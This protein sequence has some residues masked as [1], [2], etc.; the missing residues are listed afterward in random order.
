MIQLS[1]DEAEIAPGRAYRWQLSFPGP[2]PVPASRRPT[3]FNQAAHLAAARSAQAVNRPAP[4]ALAIACGF[5]LPGSV[6]LPTLEAAFL[7]LVCRHEVLR[8]H[9][10]HTDRGVA[11]HVRAPDEARL[12]R[13]EAGRLPS[14]TA[15][16]AHLHELLRLVDP[17]AGPLV[18]MG[19]VVRESSTTV[20]I[21]YDH[22]VA[23]LLSAPITVADLARAYDDLAH[24][25]EPDPTPAGSY[26]DFAREE[27]AHNL[28]LRAHDER[29]RHWQD[30]VTRGARFT[31]AFPLDLGIQEGRLLPPVNRTRTLLSAPLTQ[32]LETACRASGGTLLA[33]LLAAMAAAVRDEG[34]PDVYRA[35]VP[36]NRRGRHQYARSVG[37]FVNA[38]PVEIPAPH[39]T[40]LTAVIPLARA[41]FDAGRH[42]AD[43]HLVRAQQLLGRTNGIEADT[44]SVNFL[45][46]LDFRT[47]P[48]A[49]HAATRTAAVHVW[50][51]ACNGN[52][53]WMHRTHSGLHLNTLHP[54]T[55]RA[56]RTVASLMR[57]LS[58]TLR[59]L[60][61]E[62]RRPVAPGAGS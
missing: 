5:E 57:T 61:E 51:P 42:Q 38:V 37:W 21:V 44:S 50:S 7:H 53:A 62:P 47:A 17:V 49:E 3:S 22:L 18:A 23:D 28:G 33:G 39:H 13:T 31:P 9:C 20:H 36:V 43:V 41:A 56:R 24:G 52:L 48:G 11:V 6:D 27:R 29:L 8:T 40:P 1:A 15:A 14:R 59:T 16:R 54:D 60:A 30:F 46:Y 10:R 58:R 2:G 34:G 25:R 19:A 26:V 4:F 35:L 32:Q 45:S 55:P 12:E